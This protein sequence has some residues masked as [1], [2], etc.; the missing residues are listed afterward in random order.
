MES[1]WLQ[2]EWQDLT[3]NVHSKQNKK[4]MNVYYGPV[5]VLDTGNGSNKQSLYSNS[6]SQSL[7]PNRKQ[8]ISK[9]VKHMVCQM[10]VRWLIYT[11]SIIYTL[12]IGKL[13]L[14]G[15]DITVLL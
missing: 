11:S 5:T 6:V 7:H 10:V 13:S 3:S 1:K 8:A 2:Y 12:Q 15:N 9:L 14:I 4:K